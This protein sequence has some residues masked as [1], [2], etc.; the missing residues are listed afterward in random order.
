M[1]LGG[2]VYRSVLESLPVGV[3]LVGQ[4]RRIVLWNSGAERLTG[5]L[6]QEVV[7]RRCAEGLLMHSGADNA[8]LCGDACP[9]NATMR[10]GIPREVDVYLLHKDGQRI[11]VRVQALPLRDEYGAL[12]GAAE[13]FDVRVVLPTAAVA[14]R[15]AVNLSM[16]GVT[17]LPDRGA[18]LDWL[19]GAV[20]DSAE[21]S[22]PFGILS[23]A[24]D[25]LD[26]LLHKDGRNAVDAALY[27]TGQTLRANVGPNDMVARWSADRFVAVLTNCTART[28]AA[29][30][31]MLK[32]LATSEAIPWWGDLLTVTVSM[33]GAVV[34]PGDTPTL[35]V[36]RAEE[37]LE[38]GRSAGEGAVVLL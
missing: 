6:S 34:R 18:A 27:A 37:A 32:R 4:D 38:A 21:A 17:E 13:C 10:D 35:L 30:A 9:L 16:D 19:S 22:L 25:N 5:H 20:G 15:A 12:I 23:V 36:R 2:E 7:G 33:G 8:I 1:E 26:G 24:I 11:P 29:A 14:P 3:Y 28:L 31:A